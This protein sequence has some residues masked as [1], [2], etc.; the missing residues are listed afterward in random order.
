MHAKSV[1]IYNPKY[2]LKYFIYEKMVRKKV[3]QD[4]EGHLTI[5]KT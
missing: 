1:L 2:L 5:L 4:R 3:D